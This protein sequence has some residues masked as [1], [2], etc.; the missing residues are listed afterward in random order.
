MCNA[1]D[2]RGRSP[3]RCYRSGVLHQTSNLLHHVVA[4]VLAKGADELGQAGLRPT[5][6][7]VLQGGIGALVVGRIA[8][9]E[10]CH[11]TLTGIAQELVDVLPLASH[12]GCHQLQDVN[13]C[14]AE[15]LQVRHR[16]L[17]TPGFTKAYPP[18][19][20]SHALLALVGLV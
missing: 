5:D 1:S 14:G 2:K 20:N 15:E 17:Q 10:S 12:L 4:A 8:I 3:A 7:P 18:F 13:A 9:G 11:L 19:P 6:G 16:G